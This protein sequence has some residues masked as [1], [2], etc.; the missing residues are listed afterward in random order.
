MK[1]FVLHPVT[2]KVIHHMPYSFVNHSEHSTGNVFSEIEK[3]LKFTDG[4]LIGV[5]FIISVRMIEK[6]G[7]QSKSFPIWSLQAL[8]TMDTIQERAKNALLPINEESAGLLQPGEIENTKLLHDGNQDEQSAPAEKSPSPAKPKSTTVSIIDPPSGESNKVR[9]NLVSTLIEYRDEI[10]KED[11][12]SF[13]SK[14]TLFIKRNWNRD[15]DSLSETELRH[16]IS[17][18][19]EMHKKKNGD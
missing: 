3:I 16:C 8:G 14:M 12:K 11:E 19:A 1:A 4:Q 18:L 15:F 2:G 5:P 13:N 10:Y 9:A 6:P 7:K 17:R